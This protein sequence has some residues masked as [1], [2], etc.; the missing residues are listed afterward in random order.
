[1]GSQK[2][3]DSMGFNRGSGNIVGLVGGGTWFVLMQANQKTAATAFLIGFLAGTAANTLGPQLLGLEEE[4]EI[5]IGLGL[6]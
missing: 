1:L 5:N 2:I 4:S 6:R 3:N